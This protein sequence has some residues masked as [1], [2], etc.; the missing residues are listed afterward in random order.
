[1]RP[2]GYVVTDL[3][4]LED[5]VLDDPVVELEAAPSIK[6]SPTTIEVNPKAWKS[7]SDISPTASVD[8]S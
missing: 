7:P 1:M 2:E 6:N 4:Q 5:F 3:V 8:L